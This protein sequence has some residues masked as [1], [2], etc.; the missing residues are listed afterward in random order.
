MNSNQM[1]TTN[2]MRS[3]PAKPFSYL[4]NNETTNDQVSSGATIAHMK[5]LDLA[6]L[7]AEISCSERQRQE[8]FDLSSQL[9]VQLI[10]ARSALD[11]DGEV[12]EEV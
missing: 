9:R 5:T 8:M 10:K 2:N 3:M 7:D 1:T 6:N 11:R 4:S 12:N